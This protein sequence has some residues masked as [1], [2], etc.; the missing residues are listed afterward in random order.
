[1]K[2]SLELK[3]LLG[4][5]EKSEIGSHCLPVLS[6]IPLQTVSAIQKWKT[7]GSEMTMSMKAII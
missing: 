5:S 4:Q 1:M 3:V 2:V 6:G 7:T